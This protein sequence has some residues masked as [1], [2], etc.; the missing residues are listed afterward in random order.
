MKTRSAPRRHR[1]ANASGFTLVELM[2]ALTGGLF[3]SLAVFALARDSGRFY[4]RESRLANATVG[5]L[6]GFERLR[7][8]I[9]RAGF[10]S[11]PNIARDTHVCTQP[12]ASWPAGLRDLASVQIQTA[13]ATGV[14]A[15]NGRN[16]QSI[17]LAGSFASN[18]VYPAKIVNNGPTVSL[19]IRPG[20]TALARLA[21]GP[22]APT[23][24]MM[25]AVFAIG[26]TLRIVQYGRQYYAQILNA[27]GGSN[28][29]VIAD[30]NT[31][32]LQFRSGSATGCGLDIIGSGA[33]EATINVVNFVHYD[34]RNLATNNQ[35]PLGQSNYAS[36][37]TQSANGPGEAG[38][39][40]LVRVEQGAN[41][42]PINGTEELVAEY[43]VDLGFQI[44]AVT[45]L[46]NGTSVAVQPGSATFTNFTTNVFGTASQPELIRTVRVRLGVRS[47]ESDR[48]AGTT[49]DSTAGPNQ[50]LF[51]F[52]IGSGTEPFA[53][54]RTFQADVA[55]NNQ[56]DILW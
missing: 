53:R 8:D 33:G 6:L 18:D 29:V 40:E 42:L 49:A 39:T 12:S 37:Y 34:L 52:N 48:A 13:A 7:T 22:V 41:A 26:R 54:V 31:P 14:L 20:S 30:N 24:Q 4:Q 36:L 47:R 2:V 55:L 17:T 46:T 16:L 43:A 51:R 3:V 32:P 5:A 50:G 56:R 19:F 35:T 45:N 28:P 1:T 25:Q 23:A 15:T 11:T 10:L 9:A 27:T 38:R 21:N 44:T